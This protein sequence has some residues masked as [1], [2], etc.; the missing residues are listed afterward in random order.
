MRLKTYQQSPDYVD[1]KGGDEV[2]TP[3]EPGNRLLQDTDDH[4]ID[5]VLPEPFPSSDLL[6]L[7]ARDRPSR[8]T[9]HETPDKGSVDKIQVFDTVAVRSLIGEYR[10]YEPVSPN[11]WQGESNCLVGPF[12]CQEVARRFADAP[13]EFGQYEAYIEQVLVVG[14][15]WYVEIQTRT[16]SVEATV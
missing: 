5:E 2:T 14:D 11:R 9:R 10:A 8:A 12:S 4:I 3:G 15:S 6:G 7:E 1:S 16:F 13:V